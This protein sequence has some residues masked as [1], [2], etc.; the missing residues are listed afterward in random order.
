MKLTLS[1]LLLWTSLLFL[2]LNLITES[3]T[4]N[5]SRPSA[6]YNL[7]QCFDHVWGTQVC[8]TLMTTFF[9]LLQLS[10]PRFEG[11]FFFSKLSRPLFQFGWLP[12]HRSLRKFSI[13][14]G[15]WFY[16]SK[17]SFLFH[18]KNLHTKDVKLKF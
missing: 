15:A 5:H 13:V 10:R 1:T 7:L 17:F 16:F 18:L 3:L 4:N 9:N 11:F 12:F 8:I 6:K 2:N 14:E